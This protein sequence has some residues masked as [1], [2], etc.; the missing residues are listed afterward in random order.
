MKTKIIF[1]IG[2]V[3]SFFALMAMADETRERIY[4]AHILHQLEA[5]KPLVLSAN[6]EQEKNAR[7]QFRYVSYRDANGMPHHGLLEDINAIQK[8]IEAKLD[9]K[10]LEPRHFPTI[11]GDY[12]EAGPIVHSSRS[13][14][15]VKDVK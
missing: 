14:E 12:L 6:R 9:D 8:G 1:V 13:A 5:L 10:N 15:E 7:I 3:L 11:K 2:V 4:L